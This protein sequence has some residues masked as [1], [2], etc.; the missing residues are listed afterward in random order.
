MSQY[1]QAGAVEL[2]NP[3]TAVARLFARQ[4]EAVA[5]IAGVPT[6]LG[7]EIGDEYDIDLP[8]FTAFVG[9]LVGRYRTATHPV[10][11]ALVEPV[12]AVGI[13]LVERAGGSVPELTGPAGAMDERNVVVFADG[14]GPMGDVELL[15]RA[16]D[17]MG[18]AMPW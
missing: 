14:V 15:R 2:W 4:V 1:F 11:R 8:E 12:A 18:R 16:A 7:P 3:A 6:G 17:E 5:P 13:V 10:L 9:A